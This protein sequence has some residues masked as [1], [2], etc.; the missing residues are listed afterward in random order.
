MEELPGQERRFFAVKRVSEERMA[1][2]GE[3]NPDLVGATCLW[4]RFQKGA[5]A[6]VADH[7]VLGPRLPA[8]GDHRHAFAISGVA[9]D[10]RLDSTLFG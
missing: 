6:Y 1:D 8:P 10:R 4:H 7:L 3:M 5:V 2:G 9:T